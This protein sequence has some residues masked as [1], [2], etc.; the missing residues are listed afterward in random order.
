MAGSRILQDNE[1]SLGT[2]QVER[3]PV[4]NRA[5]LGPYVWYP[6]MVEALYNKHAIVYTEEEFNYKMLFSRARNFS[7]SPAAMLASLVIFDRL[8]MLNKLT[9]NF[10]QGIA[11]F[12]TEYHATHAYTFTHEEL[13]LAAVEFAAKSFT[14]SDR[15]GLVLQSFLREESLPNARIKAIFALFFEPNVRLSVDMDDIAAFVSAHRSRISVDENSVLLAHLFQYQVVYMTQ[16]L[17]TQ[18][19]YMNACRTILVEIG[20][21]ENYFDKLSALFTQQQLLRVLRLDNDVSNRTFH[22]MHADGYFRTPFPYG[23]MLSP[24]LSMHFT[25]IIDQFANEPPA[26]LKNVLS[27]EVRSDLERAFLS[28]RYQL[29]SQLNPNLAIQYFNQPLLHRGLCQIFSQIYNAGIGTFFEGM[30]ET[31]SSTKFKYIIR[32][33]HQFIAGSGE[34]TVE[35]TVA[36]IFELTRH[37]FLK[38]LL[39]TVDIENASNLISYPHYREVLLHSVETIFDAILESLEV[40]KAREE[41]KQQF[42]TRLAS[43][44]HN[45]LENVLSLA[46]LVLNYNE[47][48]GD[49][50]LLLIASSMPNYPFFLAV[51]KA[52]DEVGFLYQLTSTD[53]VS[54]LSAMKCLDEK[55]RDQVIE[56]TGLFEQVVYFILT[57]MI[58][59]LIESGRCTTDNQALQTLGDQFNIDIEMLATQENGKFLLHGAMFSLFDDEQYSPDISFAHNLDENREYSTPK[60]LKLG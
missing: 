29:F 28:R 10:R 53:F 15:D 31:K 11:I 51:I 34:V 27:F 17:E 19:G 24:G 8:L 36:R 7:T 6:A 49:E 32:P 40:V 13:L 37:Y 58:Q 9:F 23:D 35:A 25:K 50:I 48:V 57:D 44:S 33:I 26:H 43:L 59:T 56:D 18:T 47:G 30:D 4:A 20:F 1:T 39:H 21:P 54:I 55:Q 41:K 42:A 60:R 22:F 14:D 3:M 46:E 38:H 5:A 52:F 45:E 16:A 2:Q 12:N